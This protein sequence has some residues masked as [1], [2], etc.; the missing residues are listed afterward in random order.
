MLDSVTRVSKKYYPQI[1]PEKF[2]YEIKTTK[3]ENLI[4]DD[5]ESSLSDDEL[6]SDYESGSESND[7]FANKSQIKTVFY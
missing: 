2:K 6:E 4:N 1:L 7:Q 3:L 5:L